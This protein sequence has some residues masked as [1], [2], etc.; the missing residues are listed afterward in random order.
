MVVARA[1]GGNH[2]R[3]PSREPAA[4]WV[5]VKQAAWALAAVVL[6]L[7]ALLRLFLRIRHRD[8]AIVEGLERGQGEESLPIVA[9]GR[10]ER[11]Q[12]EEL[13]HCAA[14]G[15]SYGKQHEK[16]HPEPDETAQAGNLGMGA[17]FPPTGPDRVLSAWTS[18]QAAIAAS[19][20][21]LA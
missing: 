20:G 17:C 16:Q 14:P 5:V 8:V 2:V 18:A 9:P 1:T 21:S 12:G 7:L 15:A 19:S 10:A 3:T 11:G 6:L 4:G 13:G